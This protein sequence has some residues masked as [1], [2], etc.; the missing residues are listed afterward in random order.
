MASERRSRSQSRC[1]VGFHQLIT[2]SIFSKEILAD[3][4]YAEGKYPLICFEIHSKGS[5]FEETVA[6]LLAVCTD[7][8]RLLMNV[9][10]SITET[11]G[12]AIPN[13]ETK[14]MVTEVCVRWNSEFIYKFRPLSED[15]ARQAVLAWKKE[16]EGIHNAKLQKKETN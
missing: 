6:K 7:Q 4:V 8:L 13:N 14:A 2:S 5:T 15:E 10:S 9:D 16:I 1:A 11:R 12:F 3:V